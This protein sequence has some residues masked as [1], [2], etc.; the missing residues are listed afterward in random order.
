VKELFR[1]RAVI[2]WMLA[3]VT[4]ITVT[5]SQRSVGVA[6]DEALYMSMGSHYADWWFGLVTFDHGI[7]RDNVTKT[8]G[9]PQPTDN[10]REHPPLMKEAFGVSKKVL[11]DKLHLMSE[12]TAYRFPSALVHG[13]LV[14][15]IFFFAAGIAGT[16]EGIVAALLALFLPRAVFHAGLAAFDAPIAALWFATVYAYWRALEKDMGWTLATG[17]LWGLALATK[18]TALLLP[19]ALG[20]H[21]LFLGVR[22]ARRGRSW[23]L[24]ITHRW[25][26]IA[27]LALLGPV[28]LY[29]VWPWLWF[30]PFTHV[31]EWLT[32]HLKHVHYNF[33]YLGRNWNAPKFP[34]HVAVVTTLFTV[35]V[36]TLSAAAIGATTWVTTFVRTAPSERDK[37]APGLLLV[38]SAAASIGPFFL[39]T[40]PIFGAEKHWMPMLPTLAIAG[41]V[42]VVWAARTAAQALTDHARAPLIAITAVAGVVVLAGLVETRAAHPYALTWY[43]AL[44]GGAPGGADRGMNRQFWGVAARGVLKKLPDLGPPGPVYTHDASPAWGIYLRNGLLAPG[45]TDAGMEQAGIDHSKYA[46]VIHEKHFNRHDYMIWK[47]Y[48]TVAPVFV[49][50]SDGVPIVSVYRR[51]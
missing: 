34:W 12:V 1:S 21:Y 27:S 51:P 41:G 40:T 29:I 5:I 13:L 47:S 6:R 25:E 33:E 23:A 39:G 18:H 28:T 16:A 42:G 4:V 31:R 30:A 3:L 50:R 8:W 48:G 43:N 11:H 15:L 14:A 19:F 9:G 24:V 35:P 2:G 38:L 49:L 37:R 20:V 45:Y 44:A 17:I 26:L 36:A 7:S 46:I 32:F 10:N 22:A